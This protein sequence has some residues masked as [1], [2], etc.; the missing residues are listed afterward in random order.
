L[1]AV[2]ANRIQEHH[3]EE[4]ETS[5]ILDLRR[6]CNR[7]RTLLTALAL[8]LFLPLPAGGGAGS[9]ATVA[10]QEPVTLDI[11]IFEGEETLLPALEAAFEAENPNVNVEITL[12]PEDQY[13]VKIDTALAAGSPPDIGYL[14]DRRWVKAGRILSLDETIAAH[15]IDLE[16][17][18]QGIMGNCTVDGQVYCLG[19]YTGAVPLL[20]NKTMFDEAGLDY[21]SATKPMTIDEYAAL[22][23]QLTV[24]SDD[25]TQQIWGGSAEEPY[26]WMHR[27]NMFSEDARQVE[28]F[29][30]DEP[31]KHTYQ[32][33]ADMV[34]AG[35]APSASIMESLGGAESESLF[36]QGQL[37]MVIGD[38]AQITDLEAAG[39]DYGVATLP[40]EQEG[41][42]PYLPMWTD[43]FA[44]FSDSDTPAEAADFV[45][46]LG[47][48]GQRL[49]VEVTGQPPLS[50][51]AAEEF[52]WAEQG[53]TEGRQQ[54]L[55]TVAGGSPLM[56]VPGF[57]EVASPLEDAFNQM[58][59][60]E[61][62]ADILDELAP[63]MQESLDDAW[64]TWEQ[65]SA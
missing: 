14:Y 23:A 36:L 54:F 17:L 25:I 42:A 56:F 40:V 31:T 41:D 62:T 38:F 19:S 50:A 9:Y 52:G 21:P 48:E 18:N 45:A 57:W 6:S 44:V 35:H 2:D 5:M 32:V 15:E 13:V 8:A 60:G 27:T 34:Q 46:F 24:P 10:A 43:S 64:T 51:N 28:G 39:V 53:N 55:Q 3:L 61:V 37:A 47:T 58:A 49:R 65:I 4:E 20:Y 22:A 16:D 26:W 33:L 12:I 30:N 1:V 7:T 63:R 59:A 11:W 29:V